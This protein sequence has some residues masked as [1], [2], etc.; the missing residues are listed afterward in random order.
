FVMFIEAPIGRDLFFGAAVL[1]SAIVLTSRLG[2]LP[3]LE[4]NS[5][6]TQGI[7]FGIGILAWTMWLGLVIKTRGFFS[8]WREAMTAGL[9]SILGVTPFLYLPLAS[10]TTPPSNWG[11]ARTVEGF[12][13]LL[14]R[15]QFERLNPTSSII[16]FVVQ[17]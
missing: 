7:Y 16:P 10:M 6:G 14:G 3:L 9:L 4:A 17:L 1:S 5:H 13:H 2:H 8:K 15:G 12:F 11:Y